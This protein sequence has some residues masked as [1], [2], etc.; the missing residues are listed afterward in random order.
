MS[1]IE[2]DKMAN[3]RFIEAS[4]AFILYGMGI[5]LSSVIFLIETICCRIPC[6]SRYSHDITTANIEDEVEEHQEESVNDK[7]ES[8]TLEV[9]D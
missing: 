3:M 6:A 4:G 7:P 8:L 5:G 9:L 2:L 1:S